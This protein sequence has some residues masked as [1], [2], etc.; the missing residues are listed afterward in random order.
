MVR[1]LQNRLNWTCKYRFRLFI[2]HLNYMFI[3]KLLSL[4]LFHF[5]VI[6]LCD[7]LKL[8]ILKFVSWL[9]SQLQQDAYKSALIIVL[10]ISLCF[11]NYWN[12]TTFK[13]FDYSFKIHIY[14]KFRKFARVNDVAIDFTALTI[15]LLKRGQT[16]IEIKS[17]PSNSFLRFAQA[18]WID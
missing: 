4:S 5:F 6:F 16:L 12:L 7:M 13:E 9:L 14:L 10:Y 2:F 11:V 3:Q 8:K 1:E 15:M 18:K 17:T